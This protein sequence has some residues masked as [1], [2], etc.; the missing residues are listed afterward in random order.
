MGRDKKRE[1]GS[2]NYFLHVSLAHAASAGPVRSQNSVAPIC[3]SHK[4]GE[5][6]QVL[7]LPKH[8]LTG[9]QTRTEW[10]WN[11]GMERSNVGNPCCD[12][13]AGSNVHSLKWFWRWGQLV[14]VCWTHVQVLHTIQI[15]L[16]LVR[17]PVWSAPW[18]PFIPSHKGLLIVCECASFVPPFPFAL[19][20]S[21]DLGS[22]V[23]TVSQAAAQPL[24]RSSL[25]PPCVRWYP[26]PFCS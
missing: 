9:S 3:F 23:L 2:K 17:G 4:C 26:S 5:G 12:F 10:V 19:A 21:L 1:R 11:L 6:V 14:L 25:G 24:W 7:C 18:C 22:Y 20:A 16:L 13:T 8:T 15:Q